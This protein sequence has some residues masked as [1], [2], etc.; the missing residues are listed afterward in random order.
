MI[1]EKE[2]ELDNR[3]AYANA[4]I[5]RNYMLVRADENF[6]RFCGKVT[7]IN[8]ADMI[9]PEDV[10][11]FK[12]V[13]T[14]IT[15]DNTARVILRMKNASGGYYTVDMHL[16]LLENKEIEDGYI[17]FRMF[18]LE[19][20]E[21][22]FILAR[23]NI[24]KYRKLL[25]LYQNYLFDYHEG[26]DTFTLFL[27]HSSQ[28]TNIIKCTLKE[29]CDMVKKI[30]KDDNSLD[31]FYKLVYYIKNMPE[32]FSDKI[33]VPVDF[34]HSKLQ[35]FK[36]IG[37]M[38]HDLDGNRILTG[39]LSSV[40]EEEETAI[41]YYATSEAVDL[42]TG[43]LNKKASEEYTKSIL[44]RVDKDVHYMI[45]IDV[46]NFKEINDSY[47]H[48]FGDEVLAKVANVL[49]E[50]LNGRG[51][52]GRFGGDEFYAFTTGIHSE[53][54][55]RCMLTAMKREVLALF[56]GVKE[57]F[58][59]T[60]SIGISRYPEDG[61]N[62]DELFLKAD[63]CLY[64]AKN[65]GKDRFIIYNEEKHG[66]VSTDERT[67][68]KIENPAERNES[69][70]AYIADVFLKYNND[71]KCIEEELIKI[72]SKMEIDQV[73]VYTS[74]SNEIVKCYG[75]NQKI[76][77]MKDF[78]SNSIFNQFFNKNGVYPLGNTSTIEGY[79]K[80]CYE[81]LVSNNIMAV[82]FF[83]IEL[84]D[85]RRA[86]VMYDVY[87]HTNRWNDFHKNYLLMISKLLVA[88]IL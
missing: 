79:D 17:G 36:A 8:V 3:I 30:S 44:T 57:N 12:K 84:E 28:S 9:H 19:T 11:E 70:A 58:K 22:G 21:N 52:T 87:N 78:I 86:Y 55:L 53:D 46:D 23:S 71:K 65:K 73:R 47:G 50:N 54:I 35:Y 24:K 88:E 6:Y 32:R 81:E 13:C 16:T 74:D 82:L 39:M 29:L 69:M 25:S 42:P 4:R 49:K 15:N 68:N 38:M 80:E 63:K 34:E 61:K 45:M 14:S 64:I 48:L 5:D 72:I 60:L 1:I 7:G 33:C 62:Y 56:A 76:P 31:C 26:T 27:Y 41:P 18:P 37:V 75:T 67:A 10:E 2:N 20:M 40:N 66:N 59:V 83:R 77:N 85:G 51:I 43:L